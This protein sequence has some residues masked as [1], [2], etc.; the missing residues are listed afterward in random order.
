[1]YTSEIPDSTITITQIVDD[2]LEVTDYLRKKFKKDKI[3]IEGSS[4]GTAVSAFMICTNELTA[5]NCNHRTVLEKLA[6][7]L[8]PF[9]P[10]S[11]VCF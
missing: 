7:L 8:S 4:W 10:Q 3:Y 9:A 5:L 11:C 6:V 2:G 1:M